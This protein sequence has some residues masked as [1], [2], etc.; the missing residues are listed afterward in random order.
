[1]KSFI[2]ILLTVN[3][4]C[5]AQSGK[6]KIEL[7]DQTIIGVDTIYS[8][9]ISIDSLGHTLISYFGTNYLTKNSN[10]Q[11]VVY[12]MKNIPRFERNIWIYKPECLIT[13]K[14]DTNTCRYTSN[15]RYE[16]SNNNKKL[17]IEKLEKFRKYQNKYQQKEK[18]YSYTS[19]LIFQ[20]GILSLTGDSDMM[21]CLINLNKY[22]GNNIYEIHRVEIFEI[23]QMVIDHLQ[24]Q[25]TKELLDA[26][27]RSKFNVWK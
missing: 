11:I 21:N 27:T 3:L 16:I 9:E 12:C 22:I 24:N 8:N 6:C 10:G 25:V 2:F 4:L 1:M 13:Y 18:Y 26:L 5:T 17:L 14:I 19:W 20:V 7:T 15:L 23:K